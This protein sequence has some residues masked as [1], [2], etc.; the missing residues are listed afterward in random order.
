MK[1]ILL[2]G[3]PGA[4]KGT[5]AKLLEREYKLEKVETGSILREAINEGSELGQAAKRYMNA[6]ELVPDD[7]VIDLAVSKIQ[8]IKELEKNFLLDGFPRN[9][10]QAEA[11]EKKGFS[12]DLVIFLDIEPEKLL[13]RITGRLIC[14]NKQCAAVYHKK[15]KPPK[16]EGKCDICNSL[17]Y[18]RE[19]DKPAIL[20]KRLNAY[21]E[22][23]SPLI[24]FYEERDKLLRVNADQELENVLADVS[25][26][27]G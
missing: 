10:A 13:E 16:I 2:L 22:E 7:L 25:E 15:F 12:P 1:D 27:L 11:L 21:T 19:D 5:Q 3:A 6:G 23:T 9:V 20:E 26:I 18:Q 4:G 8:Q 17:L 14:S 24:K